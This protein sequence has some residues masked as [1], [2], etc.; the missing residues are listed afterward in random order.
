MIGLQY[1]TVQD[2]LVLK[3][4][5]GCPSGFVLP[6][7]TWAYGLRTDGSI[8]DRPLA[9]YFWAGADPLDVEGFIAA[10]KEVLAVYDRTLQAAMP[11]FELEHTGTVSG[12]AAS[13]DGPDASL[14]LAA[15]CDR[16][17]SIGPLLRAL[18]RQ[19]DTGDVGSQ[20]AELSRWAYGA[21]NDAEDTNLV[22][23]AGFLWGLRA[24]VGIDDVLAEG[25]QLRLVPRLPWTWN[26]M[27]VN[28]WPVRC[29][30]ASGRLRWTRLSF[31]LERSERQARV[32]LRTAD[33]IAGVSVRL[34]PFRRDRSLFAATSNGRATA[35]RPEVAGDAAWVWASCDCGPDG[36]FLQVSAEP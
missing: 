28:D 27:I 29:R 15:L 12:Y 24:L 6:R 33:E 4:D 1:Q 5:H 21:P 11:L 23:A 8:E 36:V 32:H 22:C 9:G 16:I 17:D 2:R 35:A 34:G 20:F 26:R 3:A 31:D 14:V 30:D 7:G 13:Y 18:V 19:T 25:G 10:D